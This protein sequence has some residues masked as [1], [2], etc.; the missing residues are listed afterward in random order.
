MLIKETGSS[1]SNLAKIDEGSAF[2]IRY[3]TF[4]LEHAHHRSFRFVEETQ[5]DGSSCLAVTPT[6]RP[7]SRRHGARSHLPPPHRCWHPQVL[8][9][10]PLRWDVFT[11]AHRAQQPARPGRLVLARLPPCQPVARP[12]PRR[13]QGDAAP[14]HVRDRLRPRP[15]DAGDGP[16]LD[17]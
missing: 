17:R 10:R 13:D 6:P 16:A 1:L 2:L 3:R 8:A 14:A 4:A 12:R 9:K 15:P 11:S 5:T 7:G